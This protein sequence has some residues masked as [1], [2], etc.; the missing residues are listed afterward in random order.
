LRA[1]F[2]REQQA[3]FRGQHLAKQLPG[4]GPVAGD[5][6]ETLPARQVVFAGACLVGQKGLH[7][8]L[9][10][11]FEQISQEPATLPAD[12]R[13]GVFQPGF[14]KRARG[15][16]SLDELLG[17]LATH[18]VGG[19]AQ[20]PDQGRQLVGAEGGLCRFGFV[21][22]CGG[23]PRRLA[24]R[25]RRLRRRLAGRKVLG[26]QACCPWRGGRGLLRGQRARAAPEPA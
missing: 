8:A 23:L 9:E 12:L 6:P 17:R 2:G 25:L 14:E 11:G 20:P 22:R 13:V 3:L 15:R 21:P 16:T 19:I 24:L 10:V 1:G 5:A 26:R 18:Q 7:A 4:G